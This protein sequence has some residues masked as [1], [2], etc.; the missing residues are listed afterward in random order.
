[1]RG[2]SSCRWERRRRSPILYS[3]LDELNAVEDAARRAISA[4]FPQ[5]AGGA[6]FAFNWGVQKAASGN[7]MYSVGIYAIAR[8]PGAEIKKAPEGAFFHG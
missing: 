2:R 6:H 5:Y 1:M 3:G 4:D 8:L 7:E